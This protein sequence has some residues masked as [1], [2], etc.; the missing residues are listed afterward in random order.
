M[1]PEFMRRFNFWAMVIFLIQV[2]VV[3]VTP[4]KYSI[5][6]LV[7]LSLYAIIVG[8]LSAWQTSRVEEHQEQE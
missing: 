3:I 1:S 2:P 6:Y 8:H 7:S 4:L 5:V